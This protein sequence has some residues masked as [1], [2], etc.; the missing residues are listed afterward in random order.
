M[1]RRPARAA[2]I[3]FGLALVGLVLLYGLVR[4]SLS[5][6][7]ARD[8]ATEQVPIVASEPTTENVVPQ[9]RAERVAASKAADLP[10]STPRADSTSPAPAPIHLHGTVV[11]PGNLPPVPDIELVLV[12]RDGHRTTS[13]AEDGQY[14]F[15]S[16]APGEYALEATAPG[17]LPQQRTIT[18]RSEEPDRR[19]DFRIEA[20]WRVAVRVVTPDGE[21]L[22]ERLA[23]ENIAAGP[24]ISVVATRNPPGEALPEKG[25]PTT[26]AREVGR[27]LFL[28][29]PSLGK[30]KPLD[31]WEDAPVWVSVA[32]REF[33]LTTQR[34][35]TRV[36]ELELIV[37]VEKIRSLLGGL[38]FV[39]LDDDT[40][41]P[42]TEAWAALSTPNVVEGANRPD[43]H[44]RVT[45]KDRL[46]GRYRI[47][48]SMPGHV[49]T[50][51]DVDIAP[52]R[53]TDLGTIRLAHGV[54]IRG[55]CVDENGQ[56]QDVLPA[57]E[58]RSADLGSGSD[59]TIFVSSA[60]PAG[61]RFRGL[62][63]ERYTVVRKAPNL[64]GRPR[65]E[66]DWIFLPSV[67]D[68]RNGPIEDLVLVVYRPVSFVL[69]PTS[70][71]VDGID[72]QVTTPEG[73]EAS[74][75]RLRGS[76]PERVEL[77]PGEYRLR[78]SRD[79]KPLR[80]TPFTLG[81]ESSRIDVDP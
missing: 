9:P 70:E 52:A 32:V 54:L 79:G 12:D 46:P 41:A 36:T 30:A 56:R 5:T 47:R 72:Y 59:R 28:S 40:G 8:G 3:G 50:T 24:W 76:A 43:V 31:I 66:Q 45:F 69:H 38:T 11:E 18:L 67:V 6:A 63:G 4:G 20:S 23:R 73:L 17:Y 49:Y 60:D 2:W 81:H 78:L 26:G 44:G 16:L 75:G 58:D 68:T 62:P 10:P 14:A 74:A 57:L 37:D 25:N 61:F 29:G 80:E 42:T 51:L 64:H 65:S 1:T 13:A 55:R 35:D 48:V 39:V 33:V 19:E 77:A 21:D 7:G 71:G 15:D 53:V 22:L 27:V 34:V